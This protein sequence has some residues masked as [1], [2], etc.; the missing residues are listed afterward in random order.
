MEVTVPNALSTAGT[1]VKTAKTHAQNAGFGYAVVIEQSAMDHEETVV[2]KQSPTAGTRNAEVKL[3]QGEVIHFYITGSGPGPTPV[4]P[5]GSNPG[6]TIIVTQWIVI[7]ILLAWI[8]FF[9]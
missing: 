6:R 2:S 5:S 1:K 4:S 8:L 9:R 3:T 7:A